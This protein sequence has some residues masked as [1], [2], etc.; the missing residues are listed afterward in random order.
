MKKFLL[1]LLLLVPFQALADRDYNNGNYWTV[2]SVNTHPG[3][4]DSYLSDLNMLWRK[5]MEILKA[6]GKV[7]SYR[8]FNNVHARDGEPNLFL[9][10]EWKSA[11]EVLDASDE[12][13]DAQEKE[14]FGS[15]EK[16]A[17]AN[18]KRGEMRTIMSE[19]FLRELSFK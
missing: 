17:K 1:V 9:M 16:G 11:G 4:Y 19:T 13:W 10:I 2:T 14:L 3:M 18:I 15:I 5:S 8:M 6:D 7:L 12:Y